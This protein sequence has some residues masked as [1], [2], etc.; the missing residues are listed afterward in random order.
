MQAGRPE[1]PAF[2]T[3]AVLQYPEHQLSFLFLRK[4]CSALEEQAACRLFCFNGPGAHGQAELDVC[5][6]LSGVGSAVEQPEFHSTFCKKSVEVDSMVPGDVIMGSIVCTGVP[7]IQAAVPDALHAVFRSHVVMLH[8]RE[9]ILIHF[10][11]EPAGTVGADVQGFIEQILS[12]DRK[13]HQALEAVH[14]VPGSIHMY[15]DSA[16]TVCLS[17]VLPEKPDNLL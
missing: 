5:L 2:E 10:F 14:G 17:S 3:Q 7:V 13:I 9:K 1:L 15:V 6:N 4:L 16:G 11:A 12:A 8:G